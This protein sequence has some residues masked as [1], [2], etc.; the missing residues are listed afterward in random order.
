[1]ARFVSVDTT[2]GQAA[3]P[4]FVPVDRPAASGNIAIDDSA[5]FGQVGA[6]ARTARSGLGLFSDSPSS[7]LLRET[8]SALGTLSGLADI[9]RAATAKTGTDSQKAVAAA[10]GA[11]GATRALAGSSAVQSAAPAFSSA[12]GSSVPYVSGALAA[13]DIANIADSDMPDDRKAFEAA[14]TA[15]R[16][17]L[18][19]TVPIPG[20]GMA[21]GALHDIARD[22]IFRDPYAE[23]RREDA[24]KVRPA[25][26]ALLASIDS[27][28]TLDELNAAASIHAGLASGEVGGRGVALRGV[29]LDTSGQETALSDAYNA[30]KTLIEAAT[31][32]PR[33]AEA[34]QLA[35]AAARFGPM[36]E[37]STVVASYLNSTA[38]EFPWMLDYGASAGSIMASALTGGG[39]DVTGDVG[40]G[41]VSLL[42]GWGRS[43]DPATQRSFRDLSSAS[44]ALGIDLDAARERLQAV[45]LELRNQQDNASRSAGGDGGAGAGGGGSDGG[46]SDG[47]ADGAGAG[48]S[49]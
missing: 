5:A 41:V 36:R 22:V 8:G 4:R 16:T 30:R 39:I 35:Q 2:F 17:A 44:R 27:A 49:W 29:H 21:A 46:V 15:G 20:I 9:A 47:G 42:D 14:G 24:G 1:M 23:T 28:T 7:P 38:P 31:A 6:L 25:M 10:R 32:N 11:Y 33:G 19:L 12:V 26:T 13:W 3:R 45:R 40:L 43:T 18:E 48:G 37:A 34:Q